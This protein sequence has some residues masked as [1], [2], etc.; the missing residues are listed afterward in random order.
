[1]KIGVIGA[2]SWG[3]ALARLLA[4]KY[5]AVTVWSAISSEIEMLKENHEHVEKLK[6]VILPDSIVYTT[7]LEEA[8]KDMDII[9]MAVPSKFI[10]TTAANIAPYY[11]GRQIIVNVSKGIEEESLMTMSEVIEKEI[12]IPV[13]SPEEPEGCVAKGTSIKLRRAK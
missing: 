2:G 11:A 7:N 3:I 10:K 8:V 4:N 12:N 5:N 1:M 13:I 6:G 9:V